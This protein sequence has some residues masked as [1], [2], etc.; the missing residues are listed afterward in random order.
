VVQP[1]NYSLS[2]DGG[3]V[4][5]RSRACEIKNHDDDAIDRLFRAAILVYRARV[6]GNVIS[7]ERY[8]IHNRAEDYLDGPS[9]RIR[10]LESLKSRRIIDQSRRRFETGGPT[11][12][13]VGVSN[14]TPSNYAYEGGISGSY[15]GTRGSRPEVWKYLRIFTRAIWHPVGRPQGKAARIHAYRKRMGLK[16]RMVF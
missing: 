15:I 9:S 6:P 10:D 1:L 8:K 16:A 12:K 11:E 13:N 4:A 14:R 7:P 3:A 5:G 2:N